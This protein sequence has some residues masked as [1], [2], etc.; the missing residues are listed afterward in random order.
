MKQA[1]N[2]NTK[3]SVSGIDFTNASLKE[4]VAKTPLKSGGASF[5]THTLVKESSSKLIYK[6]S[7]AMALFAFV[8]LAVGLAVVFFSANKLIN[9]IDYDSKAEFISLFFGLIFTT[10]GVL[11]FYFFY[12]PRVF[13]KQHNLYYKTHKFKL[14]Y[15]KSK[16]WST[17][18]PLKNIR[19]LQ[20]IGETISSDNGNYNSF[21]LNL[22]LEDGSR[23][24]VVDHGSLK[25][26]IDDA[27][28]ISEF[29]NVPI[30]HAK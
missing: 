5:K 17:Y 29:L 24:N 15:N 2:L 21:E 16:K 9:S 8:F 28:V 14:H 6:P 7:I 23:K 10:A 12:M 3:T 20:I 25:T 18:I 19:A 4:S 11:M 1:K 26:I 27:H 22:V 13:D 30:W